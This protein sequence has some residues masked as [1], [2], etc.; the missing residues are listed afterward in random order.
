MLPLLGRELP[1]VADERVDPEFGTGALKITPAHDLTD[2]DIGRDHEPADHPGDR[3]R[4]PHHRRRA[5][6]TRAST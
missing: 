6:P 1:I 2:F 3:T 4:R 5:D